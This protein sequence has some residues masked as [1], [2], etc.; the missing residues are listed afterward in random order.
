MIKIKK[1]PDLGLLLLRLGLGIIFFVHGWSKFSS[2]G[3]TI[4]FFSHLGLPSVMA[5]LVAAVELL[6]GLALILGMYTDIA[7]LL[8]SIVMVVALVYVKMATFKLG[9]LGGYELD[10]A[11]LVGNLAI[12]F[13]GSGKHH[14]MKKLM[15]GN[16]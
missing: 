11:L 3:D 15:K 7:A 10:L 1:N 14:V 12:L 2:M 6:G 4:S 8:L 16:I 9:L 13:C 5:Y